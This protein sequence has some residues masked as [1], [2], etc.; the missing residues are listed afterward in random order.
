MR[1]LLGITAIAA[2]ADMAVSAAASAGPLPPPAPQLPSTGGGESG[3]SKARTMLH[4][5]GAFMTNGASVWS[6]KI[7]SSNANCANKRLV[8]IYKQ[9]SG[10]DKKIASTKAKRSTGALEGAQRGELLSLDPPARW[11][12][13]VRFGPKNDLLSRQKATVWGSR[14]L[15]PGGHLQDDA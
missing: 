11:A 6:G 2:I 9:R 10:A 12:G 4:F 8:L 1:K 13:S 15:G 14:G 7:T 5:D 3:S